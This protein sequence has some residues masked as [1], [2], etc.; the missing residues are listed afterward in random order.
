MIWKKMWNNDKWRDIVRSQNFDKDTIFVEEILPKKKG[1]CLPQL[2]LF[3]KLKYK[4]LKKK[5]YKISKTWIQ[6]VRGAN[7]S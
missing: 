7:N 5:N 3:K 1:T 4:N 6:I 2:L